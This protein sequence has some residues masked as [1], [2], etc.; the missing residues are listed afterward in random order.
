MSTQGQRL[1]NLLPAL[2]RI[3][4]AQIAQA[5]GLAQGPLESLLSL[6]DEQFAL[7][8]EDLNQLYD[9]QFIETCAP[10]V[11]PYIGDLIG[12]RPVYGVAAAIASPRAEVA[13]TISFR[14]RKGTILVLEQLARDVTGW[15][16]HAEEMFKVLA[17]TQ[18]MKALRLDE[19]QLPELRGWQVREYMNSGFDRTAHNVD[20]R[21]I[22]AQRGRYNVRNIGVF[23]WSLQPYSLT[24][25]PLTPVAGST[26][27]FRFSPLGADMP[28]FKNPVS[29]GFQ[30]AT[31][32]QPANVPAN[33][34]RRELYEDI[35]SRTGPVYY[36]EGKSLAISIAGQ[37]LNAFQIQVCNLSG[38]DGSWINVPKSDG[39]HIAAIDPELG[40]LALAAP[41]TAGVPQADC[42][43]GFNGDM[44]GGEYSSRAE[45][46]LVE[47]AGQVLSY[48]HT[49]PAGATLQAMLDAAVS[50]LAAE[51]GITH[52]AVE[53]TDS[54]TYPVT[55][56]TSSALHIYLPAGATIELRAA[57]GCRP[58]LLLNG[59]FTVTGGAGS[60]FVLN[61]LV[62][63]YSPSS[64]AAPVPAALVHLPSIAANQLGTLEVNH[65]TLVP[66]L[67]LTAQGGARFASTPALV[68]EVPDVQIVVQKSIT[69]ALQLQ[70][71]CT[72]KL[73]DSII[74]ACSATAAAYSAPNG[75]DA[76]GSLTLT[77]CTVIGKVHATLFALISNSILWAG[78]SSG[79]AW[80]SPI[81]ADRQQQGCV[82]FSYLPLGA[83]V[84]RQYECVVSGE[85]TVRPMFYALSYG[86]P[87]YLKLLPSTDDAIRRGADDG[88]EMGAFHFL[89]A[90][91][92]ET[93]LMVR[94]QEYLPVG[95]EFGIFYQN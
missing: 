88:G 81:C 53:I 57:A 76:G 33:L 54:W 38:S 32:A 20:V 5:Q 85:G 21:L 43:Y 31:A 65:C 12:Y 22:A 27:F 18:C 78:L 44:G 49:A 79:D 24:S 82:R 67:C 30:I 8:A 93:D 62:L 92:R 90:P 91:Q 73:S 16:A 80:P 7:I 9:D 42:T 94:L 41:L 68:S 64:A 77:G 45:S 39:L 84:P 19:H 58:T 14:R 89:L 72:A 69:G 61:G 48:S 55:S 87:G 26:R 66:G 1:F 63:A 23:L 13:H 59:E 6:V 86:R 25:A 47:A 50:Q 60:T 35:Q 3:K 11:I 70:K 36:G 83:V 4:D 51:P 56:A 28:L 34:A 71:Q 52:I 29:Q 15:G 74:D 37:L 2:Y 17:A 95:L 10:W 40:R 46:F 75:S